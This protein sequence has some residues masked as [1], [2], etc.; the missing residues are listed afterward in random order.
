MDLHLKPSKTMVQAAKG[1]EGE[2]QIIFNLLHINIV[3]M[4][5]FVIVLAWLQN[6]YQN[7]H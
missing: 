3:L 7:H 2:K 1:E 4:V 5:I 6:S